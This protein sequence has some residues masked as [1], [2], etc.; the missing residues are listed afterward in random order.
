MNIRQK[1]AEELLMKE[2]RISAWERQDLVDKAYCKYQNNT[3]FV[4]EWNL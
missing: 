3:D 1:M 2:E 4:E